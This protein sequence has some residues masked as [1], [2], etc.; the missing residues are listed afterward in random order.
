[1]ASEHQVCNKAAAVQDM[2]RLICN[3]FNIVWGGICQPIQ[4]TVISAKTLAY[5]QSPD[6]W[7]ILAALQVPHIVR[8]SL[9]SLP[10]CASTAACDPV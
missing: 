6:I 10:A 2:H 7:S 8:P 1:M 9:L 3:L 4:L 5:G